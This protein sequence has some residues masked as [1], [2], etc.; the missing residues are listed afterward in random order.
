VLYREQ[1]VNPAPA[2]VNA[3]LLDEGLH[4]VWNPTCTGSPRGDG[5]VQERRSQAGWVA[6]LPRSRVSQARRSSPQMMEIEAR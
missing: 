1:F 5:E 6:W 3:V 4:P 2:E